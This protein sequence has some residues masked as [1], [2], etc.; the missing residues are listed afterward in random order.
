M[1]ASPNC[2]GHSLLSGRREALKVLRVA[3]LLVLRVL[4]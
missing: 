2:L 3:G 4:F 1:R